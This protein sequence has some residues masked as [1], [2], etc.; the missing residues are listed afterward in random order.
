MI[1]LTT[2]T[3]EAAPDAPAQQ[4]IQKGESMSHNPL[5]ASP[6][7]APAAAAAADNNNDDDDSAPPRRL[8]KKPSVAAAAAS[9]GGGAASPSSPPAPGQ[10]FRASPPAATGP[11]KVLCMHPSI[12]CFVFIALKPCRVHHYA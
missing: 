8:V 7:A 10:S 6:A 3:T 4:G 2:P 11:P 12:I 9:K 1:L 5:V